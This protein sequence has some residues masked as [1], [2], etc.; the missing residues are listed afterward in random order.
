M[1]REPGDQRR[2]TLR[3]SDADRERVVEQLRQHHVEGRLTVEELTERTERADAARTL[4]DLDALGA[5]LPPLQPPA[6]PAPAT[7]P[8]GAP[9]AVGQA[10][11]GPHGS[12]PLGPVVR[13]AQPGP[14]GGLGDERP[15]LLLADLAHPRLRH[16]HRL[17][18]LQRPRPPARG[19]G[20]PPR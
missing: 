4:G 17:A 8:A 3:A 12:A 14:A 20:S 13:P 19:P 16:A 7:A 18:G 2:A 5:D 6:A 9:P 10:G 1:D 15:R 11:R